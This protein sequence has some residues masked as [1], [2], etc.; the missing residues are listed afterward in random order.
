MRV[1]PC[2]HKDIACIG[3]ALPGSQYC[4][5]HRGG[6]LQFGWVGVRPDNDDES[7]QKFP[8]TPWD[9][10]PPWWERNLPEY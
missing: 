6:K 9:D 1:L 10:Q 8:P 3:L 2:R 7:P 5:A 4:A